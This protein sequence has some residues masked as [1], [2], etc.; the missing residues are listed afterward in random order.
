M[1]QQSSILVLRNP[2]LLA[3]LRSFRHCSLRQLYLTLGLSPGGGQ[4]LRFGLCQRFRLALCPGLGRGLGDGLGHD[5]IG[6]GFRGIRESNGLLLCPPDPTAMAHMYR[7]CPL[8]FTSRQRAVGK[9]A[10]AR[11]MGE[12]EEKGVTFGRSQT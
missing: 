4:S 12:A 8:D 5:C 11:N 6:V 7:Q 10:N 1:V 2:C 9:D 3:H